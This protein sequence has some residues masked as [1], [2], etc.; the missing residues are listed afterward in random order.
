MSTI[1]DLTNQRI[2]QSYQGLVQIS[3]SGDLYDG[4]G[5]LITNLNLT[6]SVATVTQSNT[7]ITGSII[8]ININE[9]T[10]QYAG[11][12]VLEQQSK[13]TGSILWNVNNN[14]WIYQYVTGSV[15]QSAAFL[16]GPV[17]ASADGSKKLTSGYIP[18]S[19]GGTELN[20]SV[21]RETVNSVSINKN[22]EITGSLR[23]T[24]GITGLINSASYA[25]TASYAQNAVTA[26][27]IATGSVSLTSISASYSDTASYV[28][29]LR[30]PVIV[31][32]SVA[33]S[34][35]LTANQIGINTSPGVF[36]LNVNGITNV[37]GTLQITGSVNANSITGSLLGTASFAVSSS[38]AI[39]ALSASNAVT[40]SYSLFSLSASF[41][42]TSLSA[43]FATTASHALT[44]LSASNAR[45]ASFAISASQANSANTATTASYILLAQSAS[46]ATTASYA[47]T[48]N[49]T[50]AVSASYALT[51]S[52]AQF[53]VSASIATVAFAANTATSASYAI[54][55]SAALRSISASFAT[56]ALSASNA[57]SAS[58]AISASNAVTASYTFTAVSAS[59]ATNALSASYVATASVS[60]R[61]V[62]ASYSGTAS[63]INPLQQTVAVTGSMEISGSN[64]YP[65]RVQNTKL[66][67]SGSSG[68]VGI[69]TANPQY[70]LHVAGNTNIENNLIVTGSVTAAYLF[71]AW[72]GTGS[73]S[74]YAETASISTFP[75]IGTNSGSIKPAVGQATASAPYAIALGETA[76][77]VGINSIAANSAFASGTGS[78]AMNA[79]LAGV[80]G[81]SAS[82]SNGTASFFSGY[83]NLTTEYSASNQIIIDNK[84]VFDNDDLSLYKRFIQAIILSS[85]FTGT[86]TQLFLDNSITLASCIIAPLENSSDQLITGDFTL[87][88]GSGT[89]VEFAATALNVGS[90]LGVGSIAVNLSTA[91]GHLSH[92]EGFNTFTT[93]L[94][95]HAEGLNVIASGS[96]SH[97]E[98][99]STQAIG[100]AAH[101][102]GFTTRASG[103]AS[104]AE[105]RNTTASAD[106]SHAEGIDTLSSGQYSHAEGRKTTSFG[107]YSHAEGW[108]TIS[109]GAYS[110]AE[111][112]DTKARGSYSHAE[113]QGTNANGLGS[114]A[115]GLNTTTTGPWSHAAGNN[116]EAIGTAS[117]A[118]GLSTIATRNYQVAIGEWNTN[119]NNTSLF[120][121]GNGQAGGASRSDL[122][123]FNS[124]SIIFKKDTIISSSLYIQSG[125][126]FWMNGR[127]QFN[128]GT[129]YSTQ[130][131]SIAQNTSQSIALQFT[132]E[133]YGISVSESSKIKFES[134]GVYNI[135]FSA[136]VFANTGGNIH[137]WF[138]KNGTNIADTA[139]RLTLANN[140]HTIA[141]WNFVK[142][143]QANDHAEIVWQ[144]DQ[145][146]SELRGYAINGNIP[147]IPSIIVTVTQVR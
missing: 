110:H 5:Q 29:T 125:S 100:N 10:N 3:S 79:S 121:I 123:L 92:A 80:Y 101:A 89:V 52:Y 109:S 95:S 143:F 122:A 144:S 134:A 102:E 2:K 133:N 139:S 35:S 136:Q 7:V 47:L 57:I 65:L 45:T 48:A 53:A 87:A 91:F 132:Y 111:G 77:S 137:I 88:G 142:T 146:N 82:I 96:Y 13:A 58:Y 93:G 33:I 32:G 105:G 62:S 15:T 119:N 73:Y 43:S 104:H 6:G 60:I 116:T 72:V 145:T 84:S 39:S 118:A 69:N 141:A 1:F 16:T 50:N 56:N 76:E 59:F 24:S 106:Y 20:D 78:F 127:K 70:Q 135:Q 108:E 12:S 64:T 67:V 31:S 14:E 4:L 147:E 81:Y 34:S 103:D 44:A 124:E 28:N 74:I 66:V 27:Y 61:S 138:K 117:F 46:F 112:S 37:S 49:I 22:T 54:S 17:T 19:V 8:Y 120:V 98:G 129:F 51:A 140:T 126:D 99:A 113:G 18:K 128:Y 38:R 36:A 68:R 25:I 130:S 114:H 75:W 11:L 40:S 9:S 71:G 41:A 115:E 26:S 86:N 90:A 42:T 97:A 21:I 83:G 23:V 63:Y 107:Q 94:S 131:F 30:Q 85:S 55:S